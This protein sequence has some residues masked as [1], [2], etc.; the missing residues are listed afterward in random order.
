MEDD[1]NRPT[2]PPNAPEPTVEQV[3][4]LLDS[5]IQEIQTSE[6]RSGWNLWVVVAAIAAL[7][8]VLTGE[9]KSSTVSWIVI[10]RL[11]VSG[12]LAFDGLRF[13]YNLIGNPELPGEGV[14]FRPGRD[15]FGNT[16][17]QTA[18]EIVRAVIILTIAWIPHPFPWYLAIPLSVF[19]GLFFLV[20]VLAFSLSFSRRLTSDYRTR[21]TQII[22]STFAI[23]WLV[24]IF[25][26]AILMGAT[27][28]D[29]DAVRI[30]GLFLGIAYLLILLGHLLKDSPTIALIMDLRRK[31]VA[32]KIDS[33][34][35]LHE[36][37]MLFAGMLEIDAIRDDALE[38]IALLDSADSCTK[39][40]SSILNSIE[41]GYP[42]LSDDVTVAAA[43]IKSIEQLRS[44]CFAILT[45]RQ[46]IDQRLATLTIE[47]NKKKSQIRA[48]SP[49]APA[50]AWIE[51]LLNSKAGPLD[52]SNN[53][54]VRQLNDHGKKWTDLTVQNPQPNA[55][56]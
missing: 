30:S 47:F 24:S 26:A 35:A 23:S 33:T 51:G 25:L 43:K 5:E 56:S 34:R 27:V 45:K 10:A 6:A 48:G 14:R 31:L 53:R 21:I 20:M 37:Q 11:F 22:F 7:V 42:D 39:E 36:S 44:G 16:R 54:L 46:A 38:I 52:E 8:W 1:P 4:Q 17:T 19:Y 32:G 29:L 13:L 28:I 55:Q 50:I 15:R 41:A 49:S 40:A 12:S 3:L 18:L 2:L 9:L